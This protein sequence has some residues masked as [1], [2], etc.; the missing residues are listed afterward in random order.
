MR[1][2]AAELA[3]RP[4]HTNLR[5]TL[6]RWLLITD[7]AHLPGRTAGRAAG[8]GV[9]HGAARRAGRPT[10]RAFADPDTRAAIRLTLTTAAIVV[11]LNTVFGI[12]A[13]WC[14]AKFEFRG[15]S[16]LITLIDLPLAVSPVVSG[17]IYVL[18]F[19]LNGWFGAW[20]QD[21][22]HQHRLRAA[23]HHPRDHVRHLPVRGAR[24][25]PAHAAARQRRG[26]GRHHAR[27]RRL[28]HVLPCY[29]A[30]HSLGAGVRRHPLQCARD[31]RVRRRVRGLRQHP[32]SDYHD[33]AAHRDPL[34][35]VQLRRRVRGGF[36]AVAARRRHADHQDAGRRRSGYRRR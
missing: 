20:L 7:L 24:A 30:A 5:S 29:A 2:V 8:G 17:L 19:G 13:A 32:R 23:R 1:N 35:R 28:V 3:T 14:I 9:R 27:R 25:H 11:P 26:R 22:R 18:L 16:I 31:G 36:A 21:A 33:A 12:T 6:V 10:S 15:K 4:G 34:Q